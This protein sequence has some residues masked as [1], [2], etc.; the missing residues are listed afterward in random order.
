MF[1]CVFSFFTSIIFDESKT[2][3]VE[4]HPNVAGLTE[5]IEFFFQVFAFDFV[6]QA[7]DIYFDFVVA[8]HLT[9]LY[10]TNKLK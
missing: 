5:A 3:R 10:E 1:D 8:S 7:A 9:I 2:G 6:V 4:S